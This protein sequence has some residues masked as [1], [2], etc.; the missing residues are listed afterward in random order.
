MIRD[1]VLYLVGESP[2]AH[3]IFDKPTE[4]RR[5]VFC[6]VHSVT[7][8]EFWRAFENGIEPELVF[9]ISDYADYAGEKILI[10]NETR[11]RVVRTYVTHHAVELTAA[12]ITADAE[13][14]EKEAETNAEQT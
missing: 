14:P 10:Y 2:A 11:Y 8:S 1:D 7:R 4:T 12:R 3:G 9:E 5:M 13:L 6:R